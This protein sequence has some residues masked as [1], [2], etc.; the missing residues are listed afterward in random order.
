M[1]FF[2][3]TI[4]HS[5]GRG[6]VSPRASGDS[7]DENSRILLCNKTEKCTKAPRS[8]FSQY[9][10]PRSLK[11][12][13]INFSFP[14]TLATVELGVGNTPMELLLKRTLR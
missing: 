8:V 3:G 12:V 2:R 13:Q 14:R 4:D 10:R 6:C 9:G 1:N 11:A 7:A 5:L